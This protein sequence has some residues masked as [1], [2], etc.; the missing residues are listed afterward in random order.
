[1]DV[2]TAF[3]TNTEA[4][5]LMQP[6]M[7]PLDDPAED[8]Q[9]ASVVGAALGDDRF[10]STLSQRLGMRRGMVSP[11]TLDT[12]WAL[13]G[14]SALTRNGGDGVHQGKQLR[15]IVAIRASDRR[16]Q[17]NAIGIGE[18]VM[19]RPVFP[20]IRRVRASLVPPKTART[21]ELS[22]TARDQSIC[23]ASWSRLSITCRISC[24]TPASCQ[25]RS[26]RQQVIPDPHPISW[27]KS[28]QGMPVFN[29]NRIP[30]SV[31]RFGTVGRPPLGCGLGGGRH[32]SMTAQS[33]SVSS[34]LAMS[35]SSMTNRNRCRTFFHWLYC[36]TRIR[37]C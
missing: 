5:E 30:L 12:L 13:A 28:S 11:V 1:M 35:S 21:E 27:G 34:G 33:S 3:V 15:H 6:R 10:D 17:R 7:G 4:A 26:L 14:S 37:F 24:Q 22:I 36:H 20:A 29:T 19:L 9:S 18:E 16:G 23:F 31:W 8:A 25:S 32:G 2:S